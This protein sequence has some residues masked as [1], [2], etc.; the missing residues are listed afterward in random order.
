M[1]VTF[2]INGPGIN[3]PFH[4]KNDV[5]VIYSPRTIN[6]EAA[7]HIKIDTNIIQNLP[8]K[9]KAFITSKLKSQEIYEINKEKTRLWLEIAN[10]SYTEDFKIK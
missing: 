2:E 9:A 4:L 8:K 1:E 10:T 3:K 7:A 6:V 5:F